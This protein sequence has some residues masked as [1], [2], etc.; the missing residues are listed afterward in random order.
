MTKHKRRLSI[1]GAFIILIILITLVFALVTFYQKNPLKKQWTYNGRF[2]VLDPYTYTLTSYPPDNSAVITIILPPETFILVP[3]GYGYYKLQDVYDLSK[4][5]K[6][7]D[8][9]LLASVSH[10]LGIPIETS[11]RSIS[12][13]EQYRIWQLEN[14]SHLLRETIDLSDYP[15]TVMEK[16][17]NGSDIER[18]DELKIQLYFG[19]TFWEHSIREENYTVGI[20]NASDTPGLASTISRTL[21]TIGYRVVDVGNWQGE[22]I[23]DNCQIQIRPDEALV[24]SSSIERMHQIT[25]CAIVTKDSIGE[26]F[27]IQLVITRAI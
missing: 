10:L 22:D 26:R 14:D 17:S 20:F 19:E 25:N 2:T 6:K 13:W 5:V 27:D 12:Y 4:S 23:K 18:F 9:L 8:T 16:R 3:D 21:E 15:V 11:A 24:N 1:T 7:G